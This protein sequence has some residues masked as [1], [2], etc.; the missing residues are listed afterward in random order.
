MVI[1]NPVVRNVPVSLMVRRGIGDRNVSRCGC[2][3]FGEQRIKVRIRKTGQKKG[4]Q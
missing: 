4:A 3:I 2:G 1:A